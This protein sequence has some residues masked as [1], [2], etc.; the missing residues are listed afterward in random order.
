M[1]KEDVPLPITPSLRKKLDDMTPKE[2]WIEL[3]SDG[4]YPPPLEI[5]DM[6][7]EFNR[8]V[9][10]HFAFAKL[11]IAWKKGAEYLWN[12]LNGQ[13]VELGGMNINKKQAMLSISQE[14]EG[15]A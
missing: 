3:L 14:Q 9:R 11:S 1:K 7:E 6:P 12:E 13:V 8:I 5:E 15:L 4:L 2:I 10:M